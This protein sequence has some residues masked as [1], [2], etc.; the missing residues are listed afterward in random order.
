MADQTVVQVL[1]GNTITTSTITTSGTEAFYVV[2]TPGG[3]PTNA[4]LT[5]N[6]LKYY[7]SQSA[8]LVAPTLGTPVSGTLTNATGLPPAGVVG[9]AAILGVNTF[10]ALQTITQ[11]SANAGILAST[12]YSLTGGNATNMVDLAGTWNTTGTPIGIKLAITNTTSNAGA[13]LMQL[14]GGAAGATN[15]FSVRASDGRVD[16]S[17]Q[18][19]INGSLSGVTSITAGQADQIRWSSR[20]QLFAPADGTLQITNDAQ[21]AVSSF[22]VTASGT[23]QHG[24]ANAASPVAQTIA[25]QGSRAGTDSNVG[26]AN[27][28]IQ[29]GIGTGTGTPSNLILN[30]I[31]G[32][33]TGSGTQAVSAGI[34]IAGV[35]TGQLPS[36]VLGTSA[37]S[38]TATDGFLYIPTCAGQPTGTPTT[39]TGRIPMVYDTT[40]DQFWFYRSGWK[41]PKTPAG[42]AIVT[43]Q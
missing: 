42:A 5:F 4:A 19:V 29:P 13:N 25:T 33:T 28:T 2:Q 20:T 36:V 39:F 38:S 7:M 24:A 32:T 15:R 40:N 17:G 23:I 14:L 9:T 21:S 43:W 35:A 12:G 31:V 10:T 37:I 34:T 1:A 27:L 41:Q 6:T 22:T 3:T 11:A 30:G 26:G 8:V 16:I 18:L